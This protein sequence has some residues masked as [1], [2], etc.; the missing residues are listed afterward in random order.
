MWSRVRVLVAGIAFAAPCCL[1]FI[2]AGNARE[3]LFVCFWFLSMI[4]VALVFR[5]RG[6]RT[7]VLVTVV[8]VV[9]AIGYGAFRWLPYFPDLAA[10]LQIVDEVL[11]AGD[12]VRPILAFAVLC[13]SIGLILATIVRSIVE[14][15]RFLSIPNTG[16][17][18]AGICAMTLA[19]RLARPDTVIDR[20]HTPLMVNDYRQFETVA[21]SGKTAEGG[22]TD[23][24]Y[25][26]LPN[27]TYGPHGIANQLDLYLP[28]TSTAPRSL[29]IYVHGGGWFAGDKDECDDAQKSS[30][31]WPLLDRGFAVAS[32]NYRLTRSLDSVPRASNEFEAPFPAQI[33]DCKTAIRFLRANAKSYGINPQTIAIMGYSAG[34]HL[35]ALVG[36]T[37]GVLDFEGNGWNHE[38]SSVQAVVA[39]AGVF[40]LRVFNKQVELHAKCMNYP[41]ADDLIPE[42]PDDQISRLLDGPV[43]WNMEKARKASPVNYVSGSAP[44]ILIVHGFRDLCVPPHQAEYFHCKLQQEGVDSELLLLP[45]SGHALPPFGDTRMRVVQFLLSTIGQPDHPERIENCSPIEKTPTHE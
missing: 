31:L 2:V 16:V 35:A 24:A 1:I 30:W 40:D 3:Q 9:L 17:V 21:S 10:Q 14:H 7:V 18:L 15:R 36:V 13:G 27:L 39:L 11:F 26:R 32:I 12:L 44:P 19:V 41:I 4:A 23:I 25:E 22:R 5:G 34:G 8:S 33:R 42:M 45:G 37:D 29:V 6:V 20:S 43:V 28:K 38:S